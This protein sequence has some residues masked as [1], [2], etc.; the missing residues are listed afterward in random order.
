MSYFAVSINM[1]V[2]FITINCKFLLRFWD[3]P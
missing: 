3:D 2:Y 1:N